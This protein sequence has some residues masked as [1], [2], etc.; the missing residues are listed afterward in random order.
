[1]PYLALI[2]GVANPHLFAIA[3]VNLSQ[4]LQAGWQIIA[5][6]FAVGALDI[7]WHRRGALPIRGWRLEVG[8][9]NVGDDAT[10]DPTSNVQPPTSSL[11]LPA[12]EWRARSTEPWGVFFVALDSI[13]LQAHWLFYRAGWTVF[14]RDANLGAL[15]GM[16][17]VVA[18][19]LV[20][21]SWWQRVRAHGLAEDVFLPTAL[22]L[23]TTLLAVTV[24]NFWLMLI[25]HTLVW[26]GWLGWMQWCY[27]P[28]ALKR[29]SDVSGARDA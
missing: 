19:W 24:N 22:L 28:L 18:E 8:D 4:A 20:D 15:G 16:L 26:L 12:S 6:T 29:G 5:L 13:A 10:H 17:L 11:V 2:S 9:W 7:W 14:L 1:V 21:L 27:Q 23:M 3:D 25:A